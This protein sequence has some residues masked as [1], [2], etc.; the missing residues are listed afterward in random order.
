MCYF[1]QT[2]WT[3]GYWKWGNCRQQCDKEHRIGETCGL[4][5][6]YDTTYQ[7]EPCRLCDQ[8]QKKCRRVHKMQAD[9]ARWEKEGNRIATIEKTKGDIQEI[10]AQIK[11]ITNQH[12]ERLL[13]IT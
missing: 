4:K 13:D 7:K 8:I 9:I 10:T 3:C 6:V 11:L 1:E 5:L 12:N 2:R